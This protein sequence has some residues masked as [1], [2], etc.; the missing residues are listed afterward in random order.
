MRF[1]LISTKTSLKTLFDAIESVEK[2]ADDIKRKLI[3][4]LSSGIFHPIDRE[5]ILRLVLSSD[6]IAMQRP[7]AVGQCL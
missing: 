4:E 1:V 2:E 5:T 3:A 7:G 6:D